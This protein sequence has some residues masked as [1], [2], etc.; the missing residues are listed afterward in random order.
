MTEALLPLAAARLRAD[1]LPYQGA[2]HAVAATAEECAALAARLRIPAVKSL[3][4]RFRL[5]PE[6]GG[7]VVAE[8]QLRAN[9]VQSCVVT[10]EDVPERVRDQF[11]V[12]F[13]PF[14]AEINDDDPESPDEIPF[15]G[16]VIDLG[17]AATEQLALALD[18]YPRKPGAT[19]PP[20]AT[21]ADDSPFAALARLSRKT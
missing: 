16:G 15:H 6:T 19:L 11:L 5:R 12:H 17:E 7:R 8:G 9:V 14:G 4:C 18:P 10:L 21:E 3:S 2:E 1:S 13:V 20:E